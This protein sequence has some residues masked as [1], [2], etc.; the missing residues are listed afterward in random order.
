M[1]CSRTQAEWYKLMVPRRTRQDEY[2]KR[3]EFVLLNILTVRAYEAHRLGM[4]QVW[5]ET[6]SACQ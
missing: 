1:V 4:E 6:K 2:N 3:V 5:G